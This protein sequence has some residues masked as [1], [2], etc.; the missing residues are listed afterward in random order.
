VPVP[1]EGKRHRQFAGQAAAA[2]PLEEVA[3]GPAGGGAIGEPPV[4]VHLRKVVQSLA[5]VVQPGQQVEGDQDT[6][7]REVGRSLVKVRRAVNW[8][9][10]REQPCL[11]GRPNE[12][13][14]SGTT[15]P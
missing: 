2:C 10:P 9:A 15:A 11:S 4:Q 8:R 14:V 3:H 12:P 13:P 7:S 6:G 5:A 1:G